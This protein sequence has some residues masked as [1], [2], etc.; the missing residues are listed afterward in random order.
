MPLACG[1]LLRQLIVV[2]VAVRVDVGAD[3]EQRSF[4]NAWR[5]GMPTVPSNPE[6][7]SGRASRART[8][9]VAARSR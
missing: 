1:I 7:N 4:Q 5:R 8:H 9:A 2:L 3:H 6:L